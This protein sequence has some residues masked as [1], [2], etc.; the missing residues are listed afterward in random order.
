MASLIVS[1]VS[2]S[3]VGHHNN[4]G[5]SIVGPTRR[6]K[7]SNRA[8]S[9]WSNEQV[10]WKKWFAYFHCTSL[11]QDSFKYREAI[12]RPPRGTTMSYSHYETQI[13]LNIVILPN[14]S[15]FFQLWVTIDCG[16]LNQII[17]AAHV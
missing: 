5:A 17:D 9:K 15:T 16:A 1:K 11:F 2:S 3:N 8:P 13:V 4:T 14:F 12:A 7:V 10:L 6:K